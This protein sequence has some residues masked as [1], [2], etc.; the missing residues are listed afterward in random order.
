MP[1]EH[2][3]HPDIA[4]R[5]I[6]STSTP[7]RSVTYSATCTGVV[8]HERPAHLEAERM[9]LGAMLR[10]AVEE[11]LQ[12]VAP[13]QFY[14]QRH[15]MLADHIAE[16]HFGGEVVDPVLLAK[17]HRGMGVPHRVVRR[18]GRRVRRA[19]RSRHPTLPSSAGSSTS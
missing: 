2:C 14:D 11:A 5:L 3:A 12:N 15:G 18:R 19:Q 9:T 10:G 17:R 13:S 1:V 16:M 6:G 8:A 7:K 4:A